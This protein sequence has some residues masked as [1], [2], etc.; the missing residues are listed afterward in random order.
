MRKMFDRGVRLLVA[1]ALAGGHVAAVAQEQEEDKP[2]ILIEKMRHDLGEV[3]EQPTY[4]HGFQVKNQGTADL[5]IRQ[6]KPG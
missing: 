1:V 3:F 5:D 4:K 6:V 2:R